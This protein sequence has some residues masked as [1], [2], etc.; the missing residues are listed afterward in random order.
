MPHVP[1]RLTASALIAAALA[2]G[3]LATGAPGA[4]AAG[5][6]SSQLATQLTPHRGG[7]VTVAVTANGVRPGTTA[8]LRC[9]GGRAKGCPP[10][11]RSA[12]RTVRATRAGTLSLA[13][14]LRGNRLRRGVKLVVQLQDP[15]ALFVR[16]TFTVGSNPLVRQQRSCQRADG[17]VGACPS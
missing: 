14:V 17:S 16:T 10:R 1:S 12:E 11:L 2:A 15:G 5:L 8:R 6:T 3:A 13:S 4:S 7:S 9:D